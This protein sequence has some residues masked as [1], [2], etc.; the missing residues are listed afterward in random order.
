MDMAYKQLTGRSSNRPDSEHNQ[1]ITFDRNGTAAALDCIGYNQPIT[2]GRD[3]T[4]KA[5]NCTGIDFS[6]DGS[7]SWTSAPTA[8]LD[9]QLPIARQDIFVQ[10]EASP[11]IIPDVVSAQQVFI[12]MGGSFIAY[13]T[14]K[15]HDV[16][17]FPINRS[18]M[19]GRSTR[20][21]LIIPTATSPSSL[22]LSE[23]MRELGIYLSAI[24]FKTTPL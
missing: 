8:E 11:F 12:F 13:C 1:R 10:I 24:V 17:T 2:F 20:M 18:V 21:S 16:R 7:Q 14:L 9:I 19:S 5:L 22:S 15:G 23:D 3:G 4:A 6:E